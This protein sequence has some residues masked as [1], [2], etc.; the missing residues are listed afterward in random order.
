MVF[1]VASPITTQVMIAVPGIKRLVS[2]QSHKNRFQITI[3]R[4]SVQSFGFALE[5]AFEG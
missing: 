5:I 4:S 1:T 3:E 2:R